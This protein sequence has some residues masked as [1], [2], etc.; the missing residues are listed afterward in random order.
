MATTPTS[1]TKNPQAARPDLPAPGPLEPFRTA[2]LDLQEA[3]PAGLLR[4]HALDAKQV[5][6]RLA[7]AGLDLPANTGQRTGA[8]P[9]ALCLRP[10]EWLLLS[11]RRSAEDLAQELEGPLAGAVASVLDASDACR[12]FR[13]RG[14]AAPWLLGK[15]SGLDFLA[16]VG[17]AA[18]GTR[19]RLADIP[20]VLGYDPADP[21][22]P[23][24]DLV[25]D[26]S[27]ARYLWARLVDA[28]PHA[29]E[30]Y[31]THGVPA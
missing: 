26:R 17:E 30:L 8:D 5:R 1:N 14:A 20:V 25:V 16:G 21:D 28:A 12:L 3:P 10:G 29:E 19:T 18:H 2:S 31:A 24:F 11:A 23:R 22:G 13:L 15:L 9:S 6:R 4:L 27:L 7:A